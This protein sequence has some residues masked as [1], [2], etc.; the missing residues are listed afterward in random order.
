MPDVS[1]QAR[2]ALVTGASSGIGRAVALE[3]G[4]R[5]MTVWVNFHRGG[6]SAAAVVAEV[7]AA[8][9]H[10]FTCQADVSNAAEVT[11][12]F[13]TI[14]GRSGRIDVLVNNAGI[15]QPAPFLDVTEAS[16]DLV[17]GVDLKGAF[18]CAQAAARDMARRGEG[19]RIVNISSVHEELPMPG[20]TPYVCAKGG[21]GM[22]TRNLALELA[23]HHINVVG[24]GPGAVATPINTRTLTDP[25]LKAALMRE[26]PAGRIG[27]PDEVAR[28]VGYLVSDDA[29]YITGTTVFI[30]GGLMRSTGG[31]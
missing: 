19:G 28:L 24:V 17:V 27:T 16:W 29:S 6:A 25:E 11:A 12:M 10:A 4:R 3:L 2:V 26:I 15:E 22:L 20:N 23:P 18:L 9:S 14:L 30:D 7:E 1:G 21:M 8:G 31:L 5:G 13:G